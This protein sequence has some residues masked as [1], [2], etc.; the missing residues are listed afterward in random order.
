MED[1]NTNCFQFVKYMWNTSE[2]TWEI[3]TLGL[4]K[5]SLL[6]EVMVL[7][8]VRMFCCNKRDEPLTLERKQSSKWISK[9][10]LEGGV[11]EC[12]IP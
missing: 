9:E 11:L 10:L 6:E 2:S 7:L 1:I 4:S 12:R 3:L 5:R 8:M